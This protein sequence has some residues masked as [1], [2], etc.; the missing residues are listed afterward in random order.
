MAG[1]QALLDALGID[2]D[3]EVA[4]ARHG[5]GQRLRA[6]HAAH[7]AGD[8][9]LAFE[10]ATQMLL[11]RRGERLERTL[12]DSLRTDINPRAG[13]HLPVHDEAELLVFVQFSP[14]RPVD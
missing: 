1:A 10:I 2:L 6:A 14:V 4:R 9:Q 8:D 11:A 12:N 7:A 5:R 13:G 3:A